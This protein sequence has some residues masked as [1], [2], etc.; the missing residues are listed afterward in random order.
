MRIKEPRFR[1]SVTITNGKQ[2]QNFNYED[3]KPKELMDRFKA[4][5]GDCNASVSVSSDFGVKSYG[6]GAGTMVTVSLTC[7]QDEATIVAAAE[8]G[9]SAARYFAGKFQA[10]GEAELRRLLESQGRKAEF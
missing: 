2:T 7:N 1:V 5:L 8:L 10:E 6:N 4:L 3:E 9:A